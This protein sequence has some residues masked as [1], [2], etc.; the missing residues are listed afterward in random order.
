[1]AETFGPIFI[2]NNIFFSLCLSVLSR[3]VAT[4]KLWAYLEAACCS[5]SIIKAIYRCLIWF[6]TYNL[7]F[8]IYFFPL[9]AVELW[10]SAW[11]NTF[12]VQCA[13]VGVCGVLCLCVRVCEFLFVFF[14]RF[15][16]AQRWPLHMMW[17]AD[18]CVDPAETMPP[19][20]LSRGDELSS[21]QHRNTL[22]IN[23]N[24]INRLVYYPLL[25]YSSH[26]NFRFVRFHSNR[27]DSIHSNDFFLSFSHSFF[28]FP[29]FSVC[30]AFTL[31]R[32]QAQA[33]LMYDA[34]FVLVEA[35][36]KLLRKKPDQFRSY[37]MRRSTI[38]SSSSSSMAVNSSS[39]TILQQ[40]QQ[41]SYQP[42]GNNFN[43]NGNSISSAGGGFTSNNNN[44]GRA[45][46]C[47]TSKGWVIPW[48]HGDKISQYLRKV[49]WFFCFLFR[50]LFR[51][52]HAHTL[53]TRFGSSSHLIS[54]TIHLLCV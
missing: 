30:S 38:Q 13:S 46:D 48:E 41:Q 50:C 4:L 42:Y 27:R 11:C 39:S 15:I 36:N 28:L 2:V 37:T 10:H 32:F 7:I 47:N 12:T 17:I 35:F 16:L 20:W 54:T 33:A 53:P 40:Q 19:P 26:F 18:V 34:V 9:C 22:K 29:F 21:F 51:R 49:S 24:T 8:I 43:V 6:S 44:N 3:V 1:M 14:C 52:S 25:N 31:L 23:Q 5:H 45:L